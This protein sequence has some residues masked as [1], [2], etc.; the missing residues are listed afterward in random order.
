MN[1]LNL[2][3]GLLPFLAAAA[4]RTPTPVDDAI[5]AILTAL[6]NKP[7]DAPKVLAEMRTKGMAP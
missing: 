1:I 3:K 7:E 2:L 4:A 5:V 6:L